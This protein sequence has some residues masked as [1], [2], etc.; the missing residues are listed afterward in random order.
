MGLL[1]KIEELWR[2]I[3][4]DQRKEV[5]LV[6][7]EKESVS[8]TPDAYRR[9]IALLAEAAAGIAPGTHRAPFTTTLREDARRLLEEKAGRRG[10][11]INQLLEELVLSR[12]R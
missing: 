5:L 10:L 3:P 1:A 6:L 7:Q 12:R 9:A 2:E 4:A 11:R 8:Q